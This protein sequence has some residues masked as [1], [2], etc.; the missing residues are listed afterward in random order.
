MVESEIKAILPETQL[1][2][3]CISVK[4]LNSFPE[5]FSI[6]VLNRLKAFKLKGLSLWGTEN[7]LNMQNL[8]GTE[9]C[10]HFAQEHRFI[11]K[12]Q[13]YLWTDNHQG[14]NRC[15]LKHEFGT[16]RSMPNI[17]PSPD[18]HDHT[19]HLL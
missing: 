3:I 1:S 2:A 10:I 18:A 16:G 7:A 11:L 15:I 19:Q 8:L 5:G 4:I 6:C 14:K 9:K 17:R 12:L 13:I